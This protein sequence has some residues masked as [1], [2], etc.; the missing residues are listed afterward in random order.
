M[1]RNARN[2][3]KCW[4]GTWARTHTRT[5]IDTMNF[6]FVIIMYVRDL[7]FMGIAILIKL[8]SDVLFP[9]HIQCMQ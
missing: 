5:L 4:T 9:A 1:V 2:K 6:S 8:D 7:W 3:Q